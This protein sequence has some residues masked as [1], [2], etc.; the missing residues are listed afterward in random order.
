[1]LLSQ[2]TELHKSVAIS[3]QV[4]DS[5]LTALKACLPSNLITAGIII[6][7]SLLGLGHK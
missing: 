5:D 1:M 4:A 3:A 6:Y 2:T 7:R